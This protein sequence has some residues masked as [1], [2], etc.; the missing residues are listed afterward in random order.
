MQKFFDDLEP[1]PHATTQSER[2]QQVFRLARHYAHKVFHDDGRFALPGK[3]PHLVASL[4]IAFALFEGGP[5]DR[6]LAEAMLLRGELSTHIPPRSPEEAATSSQF[7]IFCSNHTI[8]LLHMHGERLSAKLRR[9]LE[10]WGRWALRDFSGDRQCDYQFQGYN[11]NMPAKATLGMILGG[12]YFGDN[13]AV[14][15]GL[16][17]LRQLRDM[18]TRRGMISEYSSPTYT[19]LTLTNLT[20]V[21][22]R[23]RHAEARELAGRCVERIWSDFLGHIHPPT[24][25][26]PGGPSSRSYT[27]DS[28]G[29]LSAANMMLWLALGDTVFLNPV[30]ELHREPERLVLHAGADLTYS[31][32]KMA[33]Y[34]ACEFSPPAHLLEWMQKRSY[35]FHIRATAERGDMG[36]ASTGEV[37]TTQH[38]E[39]DFALGTV[40][41]ETNNQAEPLYLNYRRRASASD[42]EHV[43]VVYTRYLI[44]KQVPGE[45]VEGASGP[46]SGE[47]GYLFNYGRSHTVQKDRIAM[48][49]QRPQML[50]AGKPVT[51]L[52]TAV[53]IPAHFGPV[54]KIEHRDGHVFIQDGP[55][56]LALR[57]M[58]GTDW[59]REE[60]V[61]V[62]FVNR[63][64]MISFFNYEGP[65]RAFNEEE[66][67]RTL[68]GVIAVVSL[69]R[70]ERYEDFC[71]RVTSAQLVDYYCFFARTTRY[72]LGDTEF[73]FSYAV[74]FD[75]VRHATINGKPVPRPIW[76]ADGLPSER[77]P[78][79]N[80][81]PQLNKMEIPYK[82]LRVIWDTKRPWQ[83]ISRG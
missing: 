53:I 9:K 36:D 67:G 57:P 59:G 13:E 77:L 47:S 61:R 41:G 43:R 74:Q 19:P 4:W 12:E 49:L 40:E 79:L 16:W 24:G 50:L 29:H 70:E 39:E 69:Q 32:S 80:G 11:D 83:I 23:A 37:L 62:E 27:A 78:F 54:K 56:H 42:P 3:E 20:L 7:D 63:Y 46:F 1:F 48:L 75:R 60:S 45:R 64:H 30:K 51:S 15:H 14:E 18:L 66:L 25:L 65:P 8:Q 72:R 6:A 2:R 55:I 38:Q 22:R 34:A 21:A 33:W 76:D 35:P 31:I 73:G 82:H 5:A 81:R 71:R 68:N 58:N 10:Q 52:R 17:N 28:V 26:F 44:D